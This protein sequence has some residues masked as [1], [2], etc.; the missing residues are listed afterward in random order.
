[1]GWMSDECFGV[2]NN[3]WT[4]V[5]S[6][7]TPA[8]LFYKNIGFVEIAELQDLVAGGFSEKLLQKKCR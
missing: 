2:S 4:T 6:F 8:L 5:S 1:M 7:N 3:I